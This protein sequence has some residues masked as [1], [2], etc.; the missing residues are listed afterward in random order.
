MTKDRGITRRQFLTR[1]VGASIAIGVAGGAGFWGLKKPPI[2]FIES[3]AGAGESGKILV[4]YASQYGS[5]GEVASMIATTLQDRG[6][7]VDLKVVTNVKDVAGYRAVIVGSPVHDEE[8]MPEAV[9]FVERNQ[10][11]LSK[12][13]VAYFLT[14]MTL[15]LTKEPEARQKIAT[16]LEKVQKK[17]PQV[18][19]IGHG[20]FAGALDYSKMSPAMQALYKL[21]SEDDTAGDFRDWKAIQEWAGTLDAKLGTTINT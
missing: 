9:A 19:P 14:C 11:P 13:P 17:I 2:H 12:L 16:V 18:Q 3:E 20:L 8:W 4:T 10:I 1:A 5:T 6:N 21:F 15:G 7:T